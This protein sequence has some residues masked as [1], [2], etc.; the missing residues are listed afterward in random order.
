MNWP[1]SNAA[2][3]DWAKIGGHYY[4]GRACIYLLGNEYDIRYYNRDQSQW[5][6]PAF[7]GGVPYT[8]AA[9][10]WYFNGV[11]YQYSSTG[12]NANKET[13]IFYVPRQGVPGKPTVA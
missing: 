12:G 1:S 11:P 10:T 9:G 3:L 4:N 8:L 5:S 7:N 2:L 13:G 6:N